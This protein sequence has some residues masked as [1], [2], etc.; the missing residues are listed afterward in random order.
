MELTSTQNRVM[1]AARLSPPVV[2]RLHAVVADLK[3]TRTV[4]IE[5][6]IQA[7]LERHEVKNN[8]AGAGSELVLQ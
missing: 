8:G 2:D 3:C 4:F 1:V 6:A 7:A 5:N